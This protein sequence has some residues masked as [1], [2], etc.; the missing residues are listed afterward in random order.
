MNIY[1]TVPM[2]YNHHTMPKP[3]SKKGASFLPEIK[4]KSGKKHNSQ[5]TLELC[6]GNEKQMIALP[7]EKLNK[8]KRYYVTFTVKGSNQNS[9]SDNKLSENVPRN[10]KSV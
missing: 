2:K 4:G 3:E 7:A 1:V 5:V 8:N 9:D 10:V 6:H